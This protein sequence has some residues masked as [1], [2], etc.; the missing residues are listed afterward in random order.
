MVTVGVRFAAFA[1]VATATTPRIEIA[2]AAIA[3]LIFRT[4]MSENVT[5]ETGGTAVS[6]GSPQNAHH[7]CL[8]DQKMRTESD[9]EANGI[10]AE[11]RVPS[12]VATRAHDV[13][14]SENNWLP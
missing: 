13:E 11:T 9:V 2:A 8:R 4:R 7:G 5:G 1:G 10:V 12:V 14:S 6:W 3:A